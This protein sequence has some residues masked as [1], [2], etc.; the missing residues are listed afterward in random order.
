MTVMD[1][2]A[3]GEL[4]LIERFMNTANLEE[5]TDELG[6]PASLTAWLGAAGLAPAGAAFDEPGRE[7]IVGFREALRELLLANHGGEPE[8]AAI[9]TLNRAARL[10]VAFDADGNAQLVPAEPGV[11]GVIGALL[12]IVARSQAEGTW[13]RLKACPATTCRWAFY[14]HSRNHSRT[15]CTMDVC[16]NRAKA[17]SYRARHR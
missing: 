16:G 10:L 4:A 12:G 15:W 13:S 14:D 5:G 1:E 11:D 17:R 3:P 9:A 8:P 7:R 6:D 2:P